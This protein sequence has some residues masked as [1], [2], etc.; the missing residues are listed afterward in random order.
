M[1]VSKI[2]ANKSSL[3]ILIIWNHFNPKVYQT[4]MGTRTNILSLFQDRYCV[5]T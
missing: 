4:Q 5:K 3:T 1:A 2:L